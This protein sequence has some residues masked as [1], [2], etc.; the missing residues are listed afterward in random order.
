MV[1]SMVL[2][3]FLLGM[4]ILLAL[5]LTIVVTP[6]LVICLTLL[7]RLWITCKGTVKCPHQGQE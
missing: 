7:E 1:I 4:M 2:A 6:I 5:I 3:S